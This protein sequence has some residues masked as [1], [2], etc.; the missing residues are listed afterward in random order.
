MLV[1][2]WTHGDITTFI[3]DMELYAGNKTDIISV[4][5]AH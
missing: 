3:A 2:W 5:C 4:G 1:P